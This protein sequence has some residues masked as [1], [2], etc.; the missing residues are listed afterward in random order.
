MSGDMDSAEEFPDDGDAADGGETTASGGGDDDGD[1]GALGDGEFV[2]VGEDGLDGLVHTDL[3][4]V[5]NG[6]IIE[7][8][9]FGGDGDG[10]GYP[11]TDFKEIA[12]EFSSESSNRY[13]L[14]FTFHYSG[15]GSDARILTKMKTFIAYC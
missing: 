11:G 4:Q 5:L 10:S 6:T 1:Y 2:D 14:L 13:F 15:R 3:G 7:G 9:S 12:S 8:T